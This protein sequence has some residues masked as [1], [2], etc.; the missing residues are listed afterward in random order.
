MKILIFPHDFGDEISPMGGIFH[1]EQAAAVQ[2]LGV[3]VSAAY[4]RFRSLRTWAKGNWGGDLRTI[5]TGERMGVPFTSVRFWNPFGEEFRHLIRKRYYPV[6]IREH[7]ETH[8]SPDVVHLHFGPWVGLAIDAIRSK[9][10]NVPIILTEHSSQVGL[11]RL[12]LKQR[13]LLASIYSKVDRLTA[14]SDHLALEMHRMVDRPIE[15]IPN[16]IDPPEVSRESS[17]HQYRLVS[18]GKLTEL[19]RHKDIITALSSLPASRPIRL[20]IYGAGK[21]RVNLENLIKELGLESSVFLHGAVP[22]AEIFKALAEAD[23]LIHASEYETFGCV[24]IEAMA[25][26]TPMIAAEAPGVTNL[27]IPEVGTTYPIGNV[28]ALTEKI[29]DFYDQPPAFSPDFLRQHF[30]DNFSSDAVSERWI[31]I[32]KELI[33]TTRDPQRKEAK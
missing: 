1:V 8:G 21:E 2:E 26:G 9:W 3:D 13:Q 15:V 16:F 29:S 5:V 19:K 4:I 17:A 27:I 33:E 20:D 12:N 24:F 28:E 6:L 22:K 10:P 11:G 30:L 25:V 7:S 18:I 32:Y 31:Q 14:V 23:A